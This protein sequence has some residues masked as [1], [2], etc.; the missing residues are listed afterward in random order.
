MGEQDAAPGP[1]PPCRACGRGEL[2]PLSDFGPHGAELRYKAWVCTNPACG[3]A[4][5][6]HGGEIIR[7]RGAPTRPLPAAMRIVGRRGSDRDVPRG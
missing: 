7:H 2:V 5:K 6:I 4:V 3:A 1:F